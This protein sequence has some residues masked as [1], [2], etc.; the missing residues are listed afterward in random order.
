MSTSEKLE[1][2]LHAVIALAF[3]LISFVVAIALM[4]AYPGC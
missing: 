3:F 1:V 4:A 2:M